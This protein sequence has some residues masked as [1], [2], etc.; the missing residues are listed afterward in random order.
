MEA[1]LN[2]DITTVVI[3][4]AHCMDGFAA[5]WAVNQKLG[6][7]GVHYCAA[8][9][10][11]T[12]PEVK[13]K[14][15][16][17]VDFSY[18]LHVMESICREA[19]MVVMLDHHKTAKET[20]DYCVKNHQNFSGV[21]DLER[22]GAGLAWNYFHPGTPTPRLIAYIQDRDLWKFQLEQS[23]AINA[24]L[25]SYE[26]SF[27]SFSR[28]ADLMENE[29]GFRGIMLQGVAI[30]RKQNKDI[31]SIIASNARLI[32]WAEYEVPL[33]N[34]PSHLASELGNR[35]CQAYPNAPFSITYN[36]TANMKV[37]LS[38]RS[39]DKM[40]VSEVAASFGGGG[41]KN[42]AG[43]GMSLESFV[44]LLRKCGAV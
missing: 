23:K 41:H 20:F 43:I 33:C 25:Q 42:A 37:G 24:A 27:D 14:H 26:M 30:E 32:P 11:S 40:D 9:Y 2:S 16:Y 39:I 22:S 4:H 28:L 17:I 21:F 15:V 7:V 5:A 36:I 34:T 18:S 44:S 3:H 10:G 1:Q 31:E 38:F 12:P 13:G 29:V 35:L 19:D 6:Y 8:T